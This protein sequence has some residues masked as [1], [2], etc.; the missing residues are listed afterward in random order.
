MAFVTQDG[1]TSQLVPWD[2]VDALFVGGTDAWKLGEPRYELCAEARDR[3]KWVHMGRVNSMTRLRACKVS[4]LDSADGTHV[5][6]A[7]DRKLPE[8][9]DWLDSL[10]QQPTLLAS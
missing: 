10:N 3:G 9:Y 2:D 8:V 4:N 6:F 1:C 5:R 7:P